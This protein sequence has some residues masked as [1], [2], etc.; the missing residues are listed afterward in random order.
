MDACFNMKENRN[1]ENLEVFKGMKGIKEVK[2][3][4][5]R[6][7]VRTGKNGKPDEILAIVMRRD[8]KDVSEKFKN[9]FK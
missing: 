1:K 6:M 5:T 7:L 2:L 9:E 8:L 3:N 4:D